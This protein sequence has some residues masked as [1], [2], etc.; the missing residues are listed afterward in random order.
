M[1]WEGVIWIPV[2]DMLR[3]KRGHRP[4]DTRAAVVRLEDE[5]EGCRAAAVFDSGG[6]SIYLY[7]RHATFWWESCPN[8]FKI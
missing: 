1:V 4:R 2:V 7:L 3:M 8:V 5:G 6:S